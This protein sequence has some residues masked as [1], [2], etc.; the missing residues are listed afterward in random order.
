M[1]LSTRLMG[2][3]LSRVMRANFL[4]IGKLP[5]FPK[6]SCPYKSDLFNHRRNVRKSQWIFDIFLLS[7]PLR[8]HPLSP[9]L[10]YR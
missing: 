10:Q 6:Q 4:S 9:V 8:G 1:R 7:P 5:S 3:S 2:K